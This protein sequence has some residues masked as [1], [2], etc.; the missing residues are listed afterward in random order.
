MRRGNAD[1][2]IKTNKKDF[3]EKAKKR[4]KVGLILNEFGEQ[5]KIHVHENEIQAEIQ[6]QLKMMPGQEKMVM[7][8]YQKNASAV[9][10]L[11]GTIYED[12]IIKLIKS[13]IKVN[14]KE[15]TKDEAEKI[16]K[17]ENDNNIKEQTKGEDKTKP[18]DKKISSPK[19]TE[20]TTKA[21]PTNKKPNKTKKVSKK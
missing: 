11:R 13:K 10:A 9:K 21:K 4:I 16:L 14:N 7:E 1:D 19:K 6:K 18:K 15:L 17:A 8:Y 5:N 2:E 20:P 3:E 12:K